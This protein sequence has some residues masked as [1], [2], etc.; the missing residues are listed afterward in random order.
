MAK[1]YESYKDS[2]IAWIGEIPSEWKVCR[3]KN[4]CIIQSGSPFDSSKF[5]NVEG[6]PLI[7][8]RDI[9]SG[10]IE[11]YYEGEYSDEFIVHKG[12]LLVGM[13]GDF[14]VRIWQNND[15]LLN[16]RCCR[17]FANNDVDQTFIYFTLP[18]ILERINKLAYS[19]TVKHLSTTDLYDSFIM[20]PSLKEQHSIASFLDTKCGEIDSLISL[21]EEMISELQAYKQSVITEAVTKGLD[22]NAK[23]NCCASREKNDACI[24]SSETQPAIERKF[25]DSGVEWIGE[26]PKEWRITKI[27]RIANTTSGS[28]PRNITNDNEASIKWFRTTDIN[29]NI[30]AD[31][32]IHLTE[33]EFKSASCPMLKPNTCLVAMYGGA[34]TIGKFGMLSEEATINQALCSIEPYDMMHSKY[35]FYILKGIRTYWMKY[36][37][38]TRKDP[39]IN[40]EVVRNMLIPVP[41]LSE[42]QAIASYLD[43]KTSQIDSLISLKQQK[44]DELK[45][46]KKSIIYEYVT[47]K[48]RV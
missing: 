10:R 8:I 26:I 25:K 14:N 35:I 6:F 43:D 41:P 7:R 20:L 36:A 38:G 23:M 44:I 18:Y 39:N 31:S 22:P 32:P 15:A 13:D 27:K 3:Y 24:S 30:V 19:T 4:L 33:S 47:G 2:G 16:Q 48:K 21:Q 28:T 37:S 29:E 40:Q 34:G 45:S 5:S 12:D 9:T 42:Q 46:Y 1:T 17:I 11:T